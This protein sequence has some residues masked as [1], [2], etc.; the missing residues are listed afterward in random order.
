MHAPAGQLQTQY[1]E[2]RLFSTSNFNM[3][4]NEAYPAQG[5]RIVMGFGAVDMEA[6]PRADFCPTPASP[7]EKFFG[8][9]ACL[10]HRQSNLH[11]TPDG[12]QGL[13]YGVINK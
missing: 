2:L 11:R 5:R 12:S 9:G 8:P 13:R 3:G 4:L 1:G 7:Q 6:T 10:Y